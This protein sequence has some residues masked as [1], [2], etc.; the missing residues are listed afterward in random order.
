MAGM[1]FSFDGVDGAGKSTQVSRFRAWLEER[2]LPVVCCRDPGSTQLGEAVRQILLHQAEMPVGIRAEMC[3]YMASRAQLVE[4]VIQP[5]LAAGKIV[6]SD[7]F[8]LAN[9]AYQGH[10]TQLGPQAVW[11]VGHIATAG[12]LP[13]LTFVLDL[14]VLAA[15]RR[16]QGTPDR[17]ESRGTEFQRRV[18]RGFLAE[19]AA[20]PGRMLVVD[21]ARSIEEIQ[22]DI[23]RAA[24]G[25]LT[26]Y[27]K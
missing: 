8:L 10:A 3:L 11:E 12:V 5:A 14:D 24:E 26:G 6:V 1:F 21:A 4:E 20:H 7:R 19:A 16:R 13:D 2:G 9:V 27:G 25:I 15:A 18:R 23:R 22:A 17:M